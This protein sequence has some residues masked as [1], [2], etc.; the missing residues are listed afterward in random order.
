MPIE[1]I[2]PLHQGGGARLPIGSTYSDEHA[3]APDLTRLLRAHRQRPSGRR[4][5]D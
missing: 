2:E 5:T 1:R 4:T 3:E